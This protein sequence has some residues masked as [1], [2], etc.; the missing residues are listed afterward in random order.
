MFTQVGVTKDGLRLFSGVYKFFETHGM[1]LDELL[2]IL[3]D[4]STMPSWLHFYDEARAAGMKHDRIL[5]KLDPAISDVYGSKFRDTV[6][7]RL[8]LLRT[9]NKPKGGSHGLR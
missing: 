2:Q 7:E 6:L 3:K 5:S 4:R 9:T 8:N 1:P